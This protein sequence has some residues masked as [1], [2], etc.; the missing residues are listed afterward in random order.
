MIDLLKELVSR[1]GTDLHV[2]AGSPPSFRIDQELTPAGDRKISAPEVRGL[3]EGI[4]TDQQRETFDRELELDFAFSV[5]GVS[6]FRVNV[7]MQRG[8]MACSVRCL[9]FEI[10]DLEVLGLPEA[11]IRVLDRGKGL[12]LVTGPTG[13][14]KSTTL[15]ALIE[16]INRRRA[17]RIITIEDP[18]EYLHRNSRAIVSQRE[19]GA[20]TL[21]FASALRHV[22]RQDPDVIMIGEM[23]DRETMY[24]ALVA[25]ETG[26][27]V[28][29]S[30]HTG[31][32]PDTVN[33][34]IDAFPPEQQEQVRVQLSEVLSCVI[35]QRLLPRKDGPGL[36]LA[37]EFLLA[38]PAVRTVIREKRSHEIY[39]IIQVGRQLGM[40]TM[41]GSLSSLI[42]EGQVHLECALENSPNPDELARMMKKEHVAV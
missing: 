6:R 31:S 10:P 37:C 29:A 15:A 33:R 13:S 18:I 9:P 26:H 1:G 7:F 38:N 42:R 14:G 32:A 41:N 4:L 21:S 19:V 40:S 3:I 24:S 35:S 22:L 23:R 30:L 20:D 12:V 2:T 27:L 17:C 8:S 34:I 36:V 39:G 11:V 5:D 25:S 28:L 16:W